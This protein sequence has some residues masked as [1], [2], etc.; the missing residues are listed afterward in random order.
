MTESEL[1]TLARLALELPGARVVPTIDEKGNRLGTVWVPYG[2]GLEI[3]PLF[4]YGGT[5]P[6]DW[7]IAVAV[8]DGRP[9]CI[10]LE[11]HGQPLTPEALHRFPLGRMVEEATLMSARPVD[12]IPRRKITWANIDEARRAQAEALKRFRSQR[13]QGRRMTD[14][15]LREVAD[16]YRQH[17]ATRKPSKAVAEHFHYQPESARRVVREARLRGFLGPAHPGRGGER[18][19]KGDDDG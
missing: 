8:I 16:V 2:P 11:C 9:Q 6:F 17:V 1:D 10:A 12:E 18:T 7:T 19:K 5:G 4:S 15:F 14:D 3:P 13:R